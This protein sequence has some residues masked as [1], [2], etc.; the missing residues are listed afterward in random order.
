[1]STTL[2]QQDVVTIVGEIERRMAT[3]PADTTLRFH[4]ACCLDALGRKTEAMAGYAEVLASDPAHTGALNAIGT[5]LLG[6]QEIDSAREMFAKSVAAEPHNALALANLAY[7]FL[8]QGDLMSA[9]RGYKRALLIDPQLA[10]ARHGVGLI[11]EAIGE[12]EAA[13]GQHVAGLQS[14]PVT[15]SAYSGEELAIE[16]LLLG[17]FDDANVATTDFFDPRVFRT[18]ALIVDHFDPE[19]PLPAHHLVFNL[20]G[21]SERGGAALARAAELL[22]RT[23]RPVINRPE[24]V[25]RTGRAEMAARLAGIPGV[26]VPK[27]MRFRCDALS[28]A[29]APAILAAH[30]FTMPFLLR[31]P[32]FHNGKH[33]EFIDSAPQLALAA[34]SM[35][36][37]EAFAIEMLDARGGDGKFRKYRVIA[38]DGK[39][40]P[41]HLA[42]SDRWKIHYATADMAGSP[43]HRAE[44]EAFLNDM[45]RVLGARAVAALEAIAGELGLDFGGIDFGLDGDGRVLL[46]EAN[47]SMAIPYPEAGDC[48]D[49][50]RGPVRRIILAVRKMIAEKVLAA[51]DR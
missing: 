4:H 28:S 14:R 43:E 21:E 12:H 20:I 27:I 26:V 22:K 51:A 40:H 9:A 23:N 24:I 25:A 38:I 11:L 33:F 30:G 47:A 42:V 8:M 48:W 39:L 31:A 45:P 37:D 6:K 41:L 13:V 16:L 34:A 35:P 7:T 3:A 29:Q 15:V 46:F 19:Q 17:T 5:L 49:Y 44:D 10:I 50:R 18:S 1:M 2:T 32:G 36:E